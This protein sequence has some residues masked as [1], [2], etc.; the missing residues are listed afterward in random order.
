MINKSEFIKQYSVKIK[1]PFEENNSY[2]EGSGVF[3][4]TKN[5]CYLATAK[6]NFTDRERRG[7]DKWKLVDMDRLAL[8]LHQIEVFNGDKEVC[9]ISKILYDYEDFIIFKIKNH[10][11]FTEHLNVIEILNEKIPDDIEYFM[12]GY[13]AQDGDG[14]ISTLHSRNSIG[15]YQYTLTNSTPY[16][17]SHIK[18]FSGSGVFIKDENIYYLV[19]ILLK[20][21]DNASNFTIFN[22]PKIIA[23]KQ[24]DITP[25]EDVFE[26]EKSSI[27]YTRMVG[28]QSKNFLVKKAHKI[29]DKQKGTHKYSDLDNPKLKELVNFIEK[30]NML[31]ELEQKYNHELADTYLLG[32]FILHKY[33]RKEEALKYLEKARLFKPRYVRY[34]KDIEENPLKETLDLGKLALLDKKYEKAKWYFER[35]LNKQISK[36]VKIEVYELLLQ[37]S[38]KK[39]SIEYY[40]KLLSLY[41]KKDINKRAEAYFQL[42]ELTEDEFLKKEN[43]T[44]AFKIVESTENSSLYELEYKI[45]KRFA[46]LY[47]KEQLVFMMK[48]ILEKLV[49]EKKEYQLELQTVLSLE[50]QIKE[51][52]KLEYDLEEEKEEYKNY[53]FYCTNFKSEEIERLK[54][55][56]K[57]EKGKNT[58]LFW[59]NSFLEDDL[60]EQKELYKLEATKSKNLKDELS[61]KDIII[62]QIVVIIMVILLISIIIFL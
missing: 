12:Q 48:P 22:L 34:R 11:K 3:I 40:K 28:R 36:K 57:R 51:G 29:F 13:S 21:N 41:S 26:V 49:K 53:K 45:T 9:N 35:I 4:K 15:N 46:E 47:Q 17:V 32:A 18:G 62:I 43:L 24:L 8:N 16:E 52:R 1:T 10:E 33:N 7:V 50:N 14:Y 27:M 55:E 19:G 60:K 42:S 61:N 39:S 54:N 59:E 37:C 20:R 6:H 23:E 44:R 58:E 5:N 30:T 31:A 38:D 2:C 56:L 25:K